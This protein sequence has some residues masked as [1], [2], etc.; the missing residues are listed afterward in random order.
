MA[1]EFLVNTDAGNDSLLNG[2]RPLP[3]PM[4]TRDYRYP[5]QINCAENAKICWQ[6]LSFQ[7]ELLKSIMHLPEDIGLSNMYCGAP[8]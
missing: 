7:I 1:P 2:T 5:P 8:V 4:F 3:E 6:K